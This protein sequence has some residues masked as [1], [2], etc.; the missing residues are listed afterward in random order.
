MEDL[1][2][3]RTRLSE[4]RTLLASERTFFAWIR[5]A[6]TA[7]AGALAILRLITFKTELHRVIAHS[8]GE[9]LILWGCILI[10]FA[11]SDYKKAHA[12]LCRDRQHKSSSLRIFIIAAPLLVMAGLL[13]AVTLP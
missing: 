10:I 4:K 2:K 12:L 6:L 5:T 7:M 13:I 9:M 8:I 3:Y 1:E 11:A